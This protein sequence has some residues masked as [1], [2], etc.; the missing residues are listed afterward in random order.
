MFYLERPICI[1]TYNEMQAKKI[2]KDLSF[3]KDDICYFPK[4]EIVT[5]DYIA[6][7]K[8]NLYTRIDTLNNIYL[9]KAKVIVTT[10]EAVSQRIVSKKTLYKNILKFKVGDT[11]N[12]EEIKEKLVA[13]G[14]ER[15][16]M[17]DTKSTF[18]INS[19]IFYSRIQIF[20][21]LYHKNLYKSNI[22]L[23]LNTKAQQTEFIRESI[24]RLIFHTKT[25]VVPLLCDC[26]TLY[27]ILTV[28]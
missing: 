4:R 6:E 26:L 14:Y 9:N 24:I 20:I 21:I 8:D 2:I 28:L 13:L 27:P 3:F 1:V 5:Y 22:F 12:L 23:P 25:T 18:S 15:T 11:I 7:S 17:A 19:G 10:I 16:K